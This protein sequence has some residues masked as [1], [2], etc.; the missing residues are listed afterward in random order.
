MN[1]DDIF[2]LC[3]AGFLL[4]IIIIVC[5]LLKKRRSETRQRNETELYYTI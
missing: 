5:C 4:F 2:Y 3:M 1:S